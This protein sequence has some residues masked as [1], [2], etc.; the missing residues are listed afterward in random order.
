VRHDDFLRVAAAGALEVFVEGALGLSLATP[1]KVA[2]EF[3]NGRPVLSGE[4]RGRGDGRDA[5]AE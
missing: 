2:W 3:Q 4:G 1:Q 5:F